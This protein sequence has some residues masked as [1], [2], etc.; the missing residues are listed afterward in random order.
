M[1]D[2]MKLEAVKTGERLIAEERNLSTRGASPDATR[3]AV[4]AI[5]KTQGELRFVHLTYHLK[6]ADTL[7]PV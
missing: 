5:A 2:V 6:M 3:A 1:F 4:E 7:T